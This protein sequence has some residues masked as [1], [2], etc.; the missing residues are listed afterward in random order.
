[1]TLVPWAAAYETAFEHTAR[2][3]PG[4]NLVSICVTVFN[5]ARF[6]PACLDSLAA[7][8]HRDLEL[9]VVDDRSERDD[10]LAVATAWAQ[11]HT[12]RFARTLVVSHI[13]NQGP[14]GARNTAF[15]LAQGKFVFIIDADN[16][17]YP[18]AIARL[19]TAARDGGFDAT[20][21]QLEIF[22]LEKRIG[23]ADIWDPEEIRRDNY[24]DI[25]A[26]VARDAWEKVAGFSHIEEGWEDYDFWLKFIDAGLRVGYVPEILCRYRA[27]EQS[28]TYT[29]A[30]VAHDALKLV[31]AFR[32]PPPVEQAK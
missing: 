1:M 13:R 23:M 17:A 10:S 11:E 4:A 21:P 25:M 26:L 3:K 14:A 5:Y 20:Y 28:R 7:Q 8:T 18:R 6:L 2:R 30:H 31:M 27:H 12:A 15:S 22:G 32:H 29:E 19:H 24:V 9:I 16:E